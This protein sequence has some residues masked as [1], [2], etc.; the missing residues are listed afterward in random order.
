MQQTVKE[1]INIGIVSVFTVLW[2]LFSVS[3]Y[4]L[5]NRFLAKALNPIHTGGGLIPLS[6]LFLLFI[7]WNTDIKQ[8]SWKEIV[9]SKLQGWKIALLLCVMPILY[10]MLYG[11]EIKAFE[12]ATNS[13]TMDFAMYWSF[14]FFLLLV[15]SFS[16]FLLGRNTM[17]FTAHAI[18]NESVLNTISLVL[19]FVLQGIILV[20][21]AAVGWFNSM[22]VYAILA[23]P[24]ALF[25]KSIQQF[26]KKITIEP[27]SAIRLHP[28]SIMAL[29]VV[30]F[31]TIVNIVSTCRPFPIG[32]DEL[33]VYM[34]IPRIIAQSHHIITGNQACNWSVMMAVG[35]LF[36][37]TAIA[38]LVSIFPAFILF[39]IIYK[40]AS[41]FINTS[42]S[43]VIAACVYTLPALLWQHSADAKVDTALTMIIAAMVLLLSYASSHSNDT[44]FS[45]KS[46]WLVTCCIL[47]LFASF[48][49][50]I[51]YTAVFYIVAMLVGV[52][53][54]LSSSRSLSIA[55]FFWI[56]AA[57]F[58]VKVYSFSGINFIDAKEPR[59]YIAINIILGLIAM[60]FHLYYHRLTQLHVI[61]YLMVFCFILFISFSPWLLIHYSETKSMHVNDLLNG[62]SKQEP[63]TEKIKKAYPLGASWN[64]ESTTL[65]TQAGS[66]NLGEIENKYNQS[67]S[68]AYEEVL[69]YLGYE[70]GFVKY[71]SV[72]WD[73]S[74]FR[75][76]ATMP[77]DTG[78]WVFMLLP[79][80]FIS[81]N[82]KFLIENI[83]NSVV[84]LFFTS[85]AIYSVFYMGEKP[86]VLSEYI[87]G[88]V[89]TNS[90]AGSISKLVFES[91]ATFFV[92]IT[93]I[94]K[95][96][97]L[98]FTKQNTFQSLL[99]ILISV[100]LLI[101][102][103][104]RQI[105]SLSKPKQVLLFVTAVSFIM[106]W[107]LGNAISWYGI[108]MFALALV[109]YAALHFN[110]EVQ[111]HFISKFQLGLMGVILCFLLLQRNGSMIATYEY[112]SKLNRIFLQYAGSCIDESE[113]LQ[114][115]NISI[116]AARDELNAH[117][118]A[119]V[120]RIGTYMNYFIDNNE[121]RVYE[122]N[123]L[124]NF[125]FM[126]NR[127][128]GIKDVMNETF[129]KAG[130]Q[131]I[132]FDLNTG[133]I[134]KTPDKS[135]VKKTAKL[136]EYV[137]ANP[138]ISIVTTDRLVEDPYSKNAMMI[139]GVKTPVSYSIFGTR[140]LKPGSI[141]LF[142]I[143]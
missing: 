95:P 142:K 84:L 45:F 56:I 135:L 60:S 43:I 16:A 51:K 62:K 33:S 54:A 99:C 81:R 137:S 41:L 138:D 17:R 143:N 96:I 88:V 139:Q 38:T 126:Y 72:L 140:V 52:A 6:L 90:N 7:F 109:L 108:A 80:L 48:A 105:I 25:F 76:V 59:L 13:Y 117:P 18:Q 63:F 120:L 35:Y 98:V 24:F 31:Y 134:D 9:I 132:L 15:W 78:V 55:I 121:T 89:K 22:I 27:F 40:L 34:N 32:F 127:F 75:N 87:A 85:L 133:S 97:L 91:T 70:K 42:W 128:Y 10:F 12:D 53:Y 68:G 118:E 141:I 46:P 131:Y 110:D 58:V 39:F 3:A 44:K 124:D 57:L 92:G 69:R 79:L 100:V 123:Q 136:F 115:V 119:G 26:F 106:W 66:T 5:H 19:G 47:A 73:T 130:I 107:M 111:N 1:K 114:G 67:S 125:I 65:L 8:S 64:A 30:L 77:A 103:N 37:D 49:F 28:L 11:G 83:L 14:R 82:K 104:Y 23:L 4:F 2:T 74:T 94:V 116:A 71:A 93:Q 36:N 129:K 29:W 113:A 61:P 101:A 122:D 102:I 21:A 20:I 86:L 50:G 112:D